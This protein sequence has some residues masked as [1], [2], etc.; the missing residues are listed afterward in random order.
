MIMMG[1]SI[2]QIWVKTVSKMHLF[3]HLKNIS[4]NIIESYHKKTPEILQQ[5][6][7]SAVQ[8]HHCTAGLRLCF[9]FIDNTILFFSNPKIQASRVG[10]EMEKWRFHFFVASYKCEHVLHVKFE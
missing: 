1:K 5:R 8:Y 6:R 4:V 2:R 3:A 10:A 7:R 9:R